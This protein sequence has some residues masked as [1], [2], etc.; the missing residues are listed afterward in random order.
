MP[1]EILRE[2]VNCACLEH[3]HL[4]AQVF[5][6]CVF[7][8]LI[9]PNKEVKTFQIVSLVKLGILQQEVLLNV[10]YCVQK[11]LT[12]HIIRLALA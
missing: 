5:A 3:G 4:R 11:E 8:A 12:S 7:L 10:P 1:E 6:T 9:T 2:F